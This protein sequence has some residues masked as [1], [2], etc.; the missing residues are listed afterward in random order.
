MYRVGASGA[1]QSAGLR[2][3]IEQRFLL[4][5]RVPCA[6]RP[7]LHLKNRRRADVLHLIMHREQCLAAVDHLQRVGLA[8]K[9][10]VQVPY[11]SVHLMLLE[12]KKNQGSE[13]NCNK[14]A[15][16]KSATKLGDVIRVFVHLRGLPRE[17]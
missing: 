12:M 1:Q 6:R 3:C 14:Q 17:L 16:M 11:H 5:E 8:P 2:L 10:C 7:L 9:G 4:P 15:A 13:R